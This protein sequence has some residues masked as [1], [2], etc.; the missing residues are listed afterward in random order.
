MPKKFSIT[1]NCV[2]CKKDFL[3]SKKT[4]TYCSKSCWGK[5]NERVKRKTKICPG[6]SVEFTP[7]RS[8]RINYCT[9]ACQHRTYIK[10]RYGK[11]VS[12][13]YGLTPEKRQ[14]LLNKYDNKCAIC[15][16]VNDNKE[17]FID[18]NHITGQVR[19]V[20]CSKCNAAIGMLNEDLSLFDKAKEY[21]SYW[22]ELENMEIK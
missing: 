12:W 14:E 4:Q 13:R 1:K 22:T 9:R 15:K 2:F 11:W 10:V 6:C 21:L 19:G 17:L 20:L 16:G 7:L 8:G 18:H 5:S 3:A